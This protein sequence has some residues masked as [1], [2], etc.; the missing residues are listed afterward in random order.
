MVDFQQDGNHVWVVPHRHTFATSINSISGTYR[1]TFDEALKD[2]VENSAAMRN[3]A[4]LMGL[5]WQ[6]YYPVAA[7]DFQI[8]SEGPDASDDINKK[9]TAILEQ[10]PNWEKWRWNMMESVWFGRYAHQFVTDTKSADGRQF[11]YLGKPV[12]AISDWLP[13]LGDKITFTFAGKPCIRVSPLFAPWWQNKGATVLPVTSKEI[14]WDSIH[15]RWSEAGPVLVIDQPWI[16]EMFCLTNFILQDTP[17]DQSD[18]AGGVRGVGIRHFAYWTWWMKN[19][20]IGWALNHLQDFGAGGYTIV[21]YDAANPKAKDEAR[22]TFERPEKR[23]IY[24]PYSPNLKERVTDVVTRL[25]P[26]GEGNKALK[27]WAADYFGAHLKLLIIQQELSSEAKG[28]G[29]GSKTAELQADVKAMVHK[30]DAFAQV[31]TPL[32]QQVLPVLKKYNDPSL[33][34]KLKFTTILTKPDPDH[35]R[36]NLDTASKWQ[37]PVQRK[38]LYEALDIP[39]PKEGDDL[40]TPPMQGGM[41][42]G[43]PGTGPGLP[44]QGIP[45]SV[46]G[47]HTLESARAELGKGGVAPEE[48]LTFLGQAVESGQL[49][50]HDTPEGLIYTGDLP[51]GK[52]EDEETETQGQP[53]PVGQPGQPMAANALQRNDPADKMGMQPD[54]DDNSEPVKGDSYGAGLAY[55]SDDDPRDVTSYSQPRGEWIEETG[56]RSGRPRWRN[57]LTERVIYHMPGNRPVSQT[58]DAP[59]KA[60]KSPQG[61]PESQIPAYKP[62][63]SIAKARAAWDEAAA[64]FWAQGGKEEFLG[65]NIL[66]KRLNKAQTIELATKHG[67]AGAKSKTAALAFLE[68]KLRDK[69]PATEIKGDKDGQGKPEQAEAGQVLDVPALGEDVSRLPDAG[70]QGQSQEA[71]NVKKSPKKSKAVVWGKERLDKGEIA[72]I[73]IADLASVVGAPDDAIVRITEAPTGPAKP[74]AKWSVNI[75]SRN[76]DSDMDIGIDASG[77]KWLHIDGFWIDESVQGSGMGTDIYSNIVDN[78]RE[79]G[80]SYIYLHAAKNNPQDENSPHNGYYTWPRFGF[81]ADIDSLQRELISKIKGRF[82]EAESILD[83]MSSRE[84]RDW[85]KANGEDLFKTQFDL[86]EGSRSM[87]IY[88]SYL[89]ERTKRKPVTTRGQS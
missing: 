75:K 20:L 64:E 63:N 15:T 80:L 17:W 85:W 21:G 82:P 10:T 86:K 25:A 23:I 65:V 50:E 41:G 36:K 79:H 48:Q 28:T 51:R 3:D 42:M 52:N 22:K 30:H 71:E 29:M 66:D 54:D 39:M 26:Q 37:L 43:V 60:S 14:A 59:Q 4:E 13:H 87:K 81:D 34:F 67:M 6:R 68:G 57:S 33:R 47:E 69:Q 74:G 11:E 16:R 9:Y 88:N 83:V 56:P 45:G 84:G 58:Q 46:A 31:D 72:G 12:R 32:T 76:F 62:G 77:K 1:F 40:V 24:V 53:L 55:E 44:G 89:D 8:E 2:G 27:E 73:K 61:A 78:A 70:T 38:W 7:A 19:E 35:L 49:E 18:L 5:M